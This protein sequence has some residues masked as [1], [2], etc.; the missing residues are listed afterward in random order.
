M[1]CVGDQREI[2]LRFLAEPTE[3]NFGGKV[4]GGSVMKWIDHAG[5]TCA[6][7]WSAQYCVTVYVG[8][9]RFYSPVHVGNLVEVQ[10]KVIQTGK[11]SMHI[12][13]DVFASDPRARKFTKTT[14]CIIVFVAVDENGKPVQVPTWNPETPEDQELEKYAIKLS[15]LRSAID[16]TMDPFIHKGSPNAKS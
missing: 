5:Y 12:A 9:I 4:H 14:H 11:S 1:H 16:E 10:A 6:V 3:V 7:A 13:V 15:E 8:G 2:S